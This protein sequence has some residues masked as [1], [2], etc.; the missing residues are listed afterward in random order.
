[1][2]AKINTKKRHIQFSFIYML[3]SKLSVTETHSQTPNRL[4]RQEGLDAL[5]Q[6]PSRG[7]G[8]EGRG[9][10]MTQ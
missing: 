5:L 8:I 1:M 3:Q 7:T 2:F 9:R 6:R 4:Q 10:T